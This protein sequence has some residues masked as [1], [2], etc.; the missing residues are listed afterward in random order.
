MTAAGTG[1]LQMKRSFI[2]RQASARLLAVAMAGGLVSAA[3]AV[4][5]SPAGAHPGAAHYTQYCAA[6]HDN[7]E[8]TRSPAKETLQKMAFQ[9]LN[10]TLTEGKMKVQASSLNDASRAELISYLIGRDASDL[11]GWTQP[12]ACRGEGAGRARIDGPA[13][14]SHFGFDRRNTRA[15]TA[16]AAGLTKGELSR[17]DLGWSLGFPD[18]TTMRAQPA[19]VGSTVFYPVADAGSLYAIDLSDPDAPCLNWVYTAPG[20]APLRTSAAYGVLAD[21][22]PL[23]VAA[24][25]DST[26]HAIDARTGKALWTKRVNFYRFSMTTGTPTVLSDRIIV[27]V[28]QYEISV[29]AANSELCCTNHGVVLSLD[30]KTGEQQWRYDTM[31]DATPQRDRGD[32]QMLWGPSG[33]PVWNSPVVDEKRRLIYFATG[34]SNSAPVHRNTNAVIAIGLDDGKERWS[35]QATGRDIFLSGCGPR[36]R[37]D[38]FNCDKDT[39]YRDVD[40]GASVILAQL[41]DGSDVLLAGQKSGTLWALQPD[42]GRILWRRDIGT[43]GPLGGIHWGIAFAEDTVFT[44]IANI[45]RPVPGEPPIDPSL[46]PG[47]YAVDARTGAIKWMYSPEADCSGDR[48]QRIRLCSRGAALSGAPTYIDGVVITG[49]LDGYLHAVD[50]T[51]GEALWKYDTVRTFKGYNGVEGRGGSIDAASITAVN[52]RLFVNSGYGMFGQAAGNA[53]LAFRPVK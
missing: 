28:S 39:V 15:L 38:Q 6:C 34:E 40:F 47:L 10:F 9:L 46:K 52:G 49:G 11:N 26:V 27:P 25:L 33:A 23:I 3:P 37:D 51:T 32:G 24:G 14:V 30:A 20:G 4:A 21:G 53:L 7:P 31:P 44:P 29:A 35:M 45:G 43:G 2:S 12:M 48:Q 42:T 18:A 8:A 36:P 13:T 1:D 19:I 16:A 5:Q 22:T 17:M 41:S 50:A